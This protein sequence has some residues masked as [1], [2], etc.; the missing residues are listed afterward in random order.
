MVAEIKD[1]SIL[2]ME[3]MDDIVWSINPKN[4]SLENL[5]LRIKRFGGALFEAKDIDYNMDIQDNVK[6]IR[7]PMEYRQH[8]FLIMKEAINNL[9]KYA[10]ATKASISAS[11]SDD[12]LEV[13][14]LD[15]GDGFEMP[16]QA[17]GNG[18]LNM[19]NRAQQ[20]NASL[21]IESRLGQGTKVFLKVKIKKNLAW[22]LHTA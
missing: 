13:T 20:M 3:K 17:S 11:Y 18:I 8:I 19:K 10:K 21:V 2:L 22:E 1:N 9:V 14:I 5:L 6:N 12:Q 16:D 7:L 15:N 4:D